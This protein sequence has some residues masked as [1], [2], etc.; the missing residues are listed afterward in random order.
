MSALLANRVAIITG[1][2]RGLGRAHALALARSGARTL[3]NDVDADAAE[4][5]CRE[6]AD[7]GGEALSSSANVQD[8]GQVEEMAMQ[9][10]RRWGQ[11]DILVNNAGILRDRTFAK[12][13][14]ADFRLVLDVHVM[15][16]VNCTRA[17]WLHMKERAYG[18]I[19]FTTSSSGLY[20]NFGQS[21]YSA[22]KMALVGFMQTLALE[23]SRYGIHVNCLAPSADTQMTNNLLTKEDLSALE[24]ER[25]SPVVVA[26]ASERA[27][28]KRIVLA[29]AGS[30]EQAHIT[31]TQG[32]YLAD[33]ELSAENL[34]EQWHRIE[35]RSDEL[36]PSRGAE[37]YQYEVGRAREHAIRQQKK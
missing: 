36:V 1:A 35:D 8:L 27:P 11:I 3:I 33:D 7:A 32:L 14:L 15:G 24:A 28:S 26:L 16:S 25:V 37:Q 10:V 6:I 4:Q 17:V 30:F 31:M 23:G 21:A 18:R 34:L 20:G 22:A 5:V 13:D 2:G 9:A 19:I 12:I 29:G